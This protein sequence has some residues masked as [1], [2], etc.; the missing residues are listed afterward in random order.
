M[1]PTGK[2]INTNK[3]YCEILLAVEPCTSM[4]LDIHIFEFCNKSHITLIYLYIYE[5][6]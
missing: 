1:D 3:K 5:F 4:S 6:I 2:V